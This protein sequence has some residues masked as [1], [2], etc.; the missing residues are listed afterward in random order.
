MASRL[1]FPGPV[2]VIADRE[3]W[4]WQHV[5][6]LRARTHGDKVYARMPEE[7]VELTYAETEDLAGR[8]ASWFYDSGAAPGDRVL[9]MAENSSDCLLAGLACVVGGLVE[10][11]MNTAY[12]GSILE[13]QVAVSKPRYAIVDAQF[14][15]RFND[16]SRYATIE[17]FLLIGDAEQ[18]RRARGELPAGLRSGPFEALKAA[19]RREL[20]AVKP[21]DLAHIMFTSGTTGPSKG[22]RMPQAQSYMFGEQ[23]RAL[24][25]LTQDDVRLTGFPLFHGQAKF[26][27]VLSAPVVGAELVLYSKFSASDWLRRVREANA[28]VTNFVAGTMSKVWDTPETPDDANCGLRCVFAAPTVPALAQGFR[29]RFGVQDVVEGFGQTE[30]TL[31]VMSPPGVARPDGA[32]GAAVSDWFEVKVVDPETDEELPPNT[33]GELVVRSK[34]PWIMNL[35]YEGMDAQTVRAWRNGWFHTGDAHKVDEHGWFTFVDRMKD[36]LRRRGENISSF[37]VET[38]IAE[39]AG[40]AECAVVGV[41]SDLPGGEQ[42]ILAVVVCSG[43]SLSADDVWRWAEERLP[44][45]MVPRYVRFTLQLPKS[46]AERIQKQKLRDEG[47]ADAADRDQTAMASS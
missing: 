43:R 19:P 5:F 44:N 8:I 26:L 45:F 1:S 47:I 12:H 24:V 41:P 28:T 9:I 32:A 38:A 46:A 15:K 36:Y 10:V 37:D 17:R 27:S 40:I 31:P 30:I 14:A 21:W 29:R 22:V 42:E 39:H 18:R 7:S 25:S 34:V 6:A 4:T 11:P 16:T 33:L 2:P 35:G 20:P 23:D 13:H 3:A